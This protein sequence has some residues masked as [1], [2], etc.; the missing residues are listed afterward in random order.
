[1]DIL[2]ISEITP[3]LGRILYG[4]FF[5]FFG[6][7][8]SCHFSPTLDF[9]KNRGIP[10]AKLFLL[11]GIALQSVAGLCLILGIYTKLAALLLIP[12]TLFAIF[13]FHAFWHLQGEAR[14]LNMI[15]FITNITVTFG[16]LLFLLNTMTPIMAF[17]DFLQK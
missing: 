17:S 11:F 4:F 7:W 3:I 8:N 9:M 5:L 2:S 16:G 10:F 14:Q 1:M 13:I 6:I 15:I 12:F